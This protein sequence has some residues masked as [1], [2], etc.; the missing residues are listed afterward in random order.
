MW[1]HICM[2]K[3][4]QHYCACCKFCRKKSW[5]F[6]KS[7]Y[8]NYEKMVKKIFLQSIYIHLPALVLT[9]DH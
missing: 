3:Y 9:R 4:S 1:T 8:S 6:S 5:P 7:S 2:D